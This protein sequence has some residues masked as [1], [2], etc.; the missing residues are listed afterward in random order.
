[1]SPQSGGRIQIFSSVSQSVLLAGVGERLPG[2]STYIYVYIYLLF[3]CLTPN[4]VVQSFAVLLRICKVSVSIP[5][6]DD[7]E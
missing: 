1:M 7:S 2:F 6:L 5:C 3:K 4:R